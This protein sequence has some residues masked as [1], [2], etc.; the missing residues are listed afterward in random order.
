MA[1]TIDLTGMKFGRLTVIEFSHQDKHKKRH[2]LCKCECGT[3]KTVQTGHL[4]GGKTTSCG[5]LNREITSKQMKDK[6]K[7]EVFK[8]KQSNR[9]KQQVQEFWENED[10][11][12]MQ[13]NKMKD[14]WKDETFRQLQTNKTKKQWENEDFRQK[15]SNGMKNKWENEDF[16]QMQT[17]K[18]KDKW[19]DET[20][21]HYQSTK[22]E[23]VT[24]NKNPNY[25]GGITQIENHLKNMMEVKQWFK[26]SK[27]E[28]DYTCQLTGKRGVKLHTHH[29]KSFN[30]IVKEGH[31]FNNI[32]IKE[33]V[34]DYTEE[35]LTLLEEYVKSW[36]MDTKNAIVLCEKVHKLF[37]RTKENGGYGKGNNTPEQFEEFKERYLA[38]EFDDVLK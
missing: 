34:S 26:N 10:F 29:L 6:W 5:C 2:W 18:M 28:V 37:H 8:Q 23:T 7:D 32:Q 27:K 25:K 31:I 19:K 20:F 11:R 33:I 1:K 12:Q 24:G 30:T 16:R 15:R 17:N 14:K 3:I 36:H 22:G 13:T 35:E 21:R 38:G 4:R 9:M